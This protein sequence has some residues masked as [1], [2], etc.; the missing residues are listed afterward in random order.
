MRIVLIYQCFQRLSECFFGRARSTFARSTP[1]GIAIEIRKREDWRPMKM[2]IRPSTV[3]CDGALPCMTASIC[4]K[5]LSTMPMNAL[6]AL[7][8]PA[9][10]CPAIASRGG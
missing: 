5:L 9:P 4:P 10:L 8:F 3:R 2:L 7:L 6:V 1:E